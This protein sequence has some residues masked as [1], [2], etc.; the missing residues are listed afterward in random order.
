[1]TTV[2]L[3]ELPTPSLAE[4]LNE[5]SAKLGNPEH[6]ALMAEAAARIHKL[7]DLLASCYPHVEASAKA[8]HLLDG[9]RPRIRPLDA[10]VVKLS[11]ELDV[12]LSESQK[13]TFAYSGELGS[14]PAVRGFHRPMP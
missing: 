11:V 9:F 7:T 12:P 8:S 3:N 5:S 2:S 6:C 4:A 13:I 1:M 10:L 14:K